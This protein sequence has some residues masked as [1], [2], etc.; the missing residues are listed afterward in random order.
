MF[1]GHTFLVSLTASSLTVAELTHN[2]GRVLYELEDKIPVTCVIISSDNQPGTPARCSRGWATSNALPAAIEDHVRAN[3]ITVVYEH[4]VHECVCKNRLL[5]PCRD[6]PDTVAYDPYLFARIH[7]TTTQ[8]PMQLKANIIALM[9]FYGATYHNHL[10]DMTN[11][12]VHSHTRLLPAARRSVAPSALAPPP[13]VG[14]RHDAVELA[15]IKEGEAANIGSGERWSTGPSGDNAAEAA[16]PSLSKLAVARQLGIPC[17]TPQWVQ[18]CVNACKLLPA[19]SALAPT[20]PPQTP[21]H[22]STNPNA[23]MLSDAPALSVTDANEIPPYEEEADRWISEVLASASRSACPHSRS[24]AT[25]AYS[26]HPETPLSCTVS[27]KEED[28][29][30][31]HAPKGAAQLSPSSASASKTRKRRRAR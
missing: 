10:L 31:R 11:L 1:R 5:L 19:E 4:W 29:E 7:F 3:R 20:L 26:A 12:L 24:A 27:S 16:K 9:Q 14:D 28:G 8:L 22:P 18:L 30:V 6:Y 25:D 13:L 17:V 15:S 23:T 2:G 21:L